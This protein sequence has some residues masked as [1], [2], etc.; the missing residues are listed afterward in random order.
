[1]TSFCTVIIPFISATPK[2]GTHCIRTNFFLFTANSS[3]KNGC[4]VVEPAD[5]L[6]VCFAMRYAHPLYY[7]NV[8]FSFHIQDYPRCVLTNQ[9]VLEN[10]YLIAQLR[11]TVVTKMGHQS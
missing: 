4:F 7:G 2:L 11:N 5:F 1:M 3:D 10:S 9:V 8:K 6:S